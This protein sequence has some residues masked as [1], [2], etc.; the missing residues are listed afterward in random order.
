M[1]DEHAVSLADGARMFFTLTPDY[2]TYFYQ[3]LRRENESSKASNAVRWMKIVAATTVLMAGLWLALHLRE[4]HEAAER[5]AYYDKVLT[6][7]EGEL[8]PGMTR[9]QV[10]ELLRTRGDRFRQMCC[11]GNFRGHYVSSSDAGWDDLVQIGKESAPWYCGENNVYVS[12]EFNPK[13]QGELSKTNGSD[14]LKRV[15]VFHQLENCL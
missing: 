14:I 11:V 1:M 5:E 12:F 13:A 3:P 6:R 7:Y 2:N 4:R 8:K 10:E 9:E 15:S